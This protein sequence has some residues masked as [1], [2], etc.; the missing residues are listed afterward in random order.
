LETLKTLERLPKKTKV[1][2]RPLK[3]PQKASRLLRGLFKA[4]EMP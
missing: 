2:R 4:F 3:G 1:F